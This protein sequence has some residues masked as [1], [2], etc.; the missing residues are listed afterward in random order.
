[1]NLK[2]PG[3]ILNG[4]YTSGSWHRFAS[5]RWRLSLPMNRPVA[6][7]VKAWGQF[8]KS[9][10]PAGSRRQLRFMDPMREIGIVE[11]THKTH[12]RQKPLQSLMIRAECQLP[13]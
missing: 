4:L 1:M 10:S 11:A 7:P 5:N 3:L 6:T 12:V 9:A 8:A 13:G 2:V